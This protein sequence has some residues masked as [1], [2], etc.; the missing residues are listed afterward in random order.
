MMSYHR[1]VVRYH[2]HR[3]KRDVFGTDGNNSALSR[4]HHD[5]SKIPD[6]AVLP[7]FSHQVRGL[8][9]W[10]DN[11]KRNGIKEVTLLLSPT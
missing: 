4:L 3:L 5:D 10:H 2:H 1:S 9:F 6:C 7:M 8:H 11:G